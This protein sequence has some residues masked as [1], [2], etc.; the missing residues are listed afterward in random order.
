MLK[1]CDSRF[2]L[3]VEQILAFTS[4]PNMV[5]EK[6]LSPDLKDTFKSSL[7]YGKNHRHVKKVGH[8]SEFLFGIY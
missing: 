2:S 7:V 4:S 1:T 3:I 8:T 5:R 6:D